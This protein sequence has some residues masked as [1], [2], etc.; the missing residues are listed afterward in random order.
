MK[1][2]SLC[3]TFLVGI[4]RARRNQEKQTLSRAL[5]EPA[6]QVADVASRST[7]SAAAEC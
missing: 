7:K 3:G 6:G 1:T 5:V 4:R 2:N